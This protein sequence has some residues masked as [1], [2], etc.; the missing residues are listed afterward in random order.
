VCGAIISTATVAPQRALSLRPKYL[1]FGLV[2]L[3]F[4]YVLVLRHNESFLVNTH[5]PVWKHYQPFKWWLLAHGLAG[6]CGLLIAPMQLS[7]RLRQ[8]Y[9]KLHR[10]MGRIYVAAVFVA[11][12]LGIY[13][14][15][16]GER[17]GD[18]RSFTMAA[19]THGVFWM[20]TTGIA[21]AFIL[22]GK[23][24][25]HRQWMTRSVFVGPLVFL[26]VR[27]MMGVTGWERL[28]P[29]AIEAGVWFWIAL[30][31]LLA[32]VMLQWQE[33]SRYRPTVPKVQAAA[34]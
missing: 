15:F 34:R 18:S 29:A 23:V 25:Q 8:H 14:K 17:M 4:A 19:A 27:A 31:I 10:V 33:L 13:I 1:L 9:T 32:D 16:F 6:A 22:K 28:G 30:S 11:G 26:G 24:Q 7:D 12:P 2:C 20:F 3:M 5:D 21:F